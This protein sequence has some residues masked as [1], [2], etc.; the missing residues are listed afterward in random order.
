MATKNGTNIFFQ[1]K[2]ICH[3]CKRGI[4]SQ[5]KVCKPEMKL[6]FWRKV[7]GHNN[8]VVKCQRKFQ[9]GFAPD[10]IG[11]EMW[12]PLC[13][14][15]RV[16]FPTQEIEKQKVLCQVLILF[17]PFCDNFPSTMSR[18][19]QGSCHT[20]FMLWLGILFD[21]SICHS[22]HMVSIW[23]W[24]SFLTMWLHQTKELENKSRKLCSLP[25]KQLLSYNGKDWA[26]SSANGS[27][28]D[29]FHLFA[30]LHWNI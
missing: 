27:L 12:N 17:T 18:N 25:K 28:R 20:F 16:T 6:N 21:L 8:N 13:S 30:T 5:C 29:P 4:L 1:A 23:P 11:W 9:V 15:C 26:W 22:E 10:G 7:A 2:K 24:V 3:G 19:N 14:G